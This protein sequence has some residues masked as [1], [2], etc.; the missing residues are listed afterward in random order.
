[1]KTRIVTCDVCGKEF[2]TKGH[3]AKYCSKECKHKGSYRG[4][5]RKRDQGKQFQEEHR[6][7]HTKLSYINE[8]A[9]ERGMTYGQFVG[10]FEYAPRIPKRGGVN[11]EC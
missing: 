11:A 8:M 2:E 9:R 10:R 5:K 6:M 7:G 1:M 3:N 4:Y